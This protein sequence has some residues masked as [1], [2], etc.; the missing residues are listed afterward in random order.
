MNSIGLFRL[1]RVKTEVEIETR[2]GDGKC[3]EEDN[4]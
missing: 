4:E 1:F 3:T 2:L